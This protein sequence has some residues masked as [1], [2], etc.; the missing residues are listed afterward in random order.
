MIISAQNYPCCI[1]H[2]DCE[3]DTHH[4]GIMKAIRHDEKSSLM[5]CLHCGKKGNY[6]VGSI[7]P[8][9]VEEAAE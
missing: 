5:E 1:W 7:G 2:T 8:V 4:S 3:V 6:P 9:N